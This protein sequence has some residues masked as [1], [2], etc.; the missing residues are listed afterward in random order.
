VRGDKAARSRRW[1][2]AALE[3]GVAKS[4][5]FTFSIQIPHC[6]APDDPAIFCEQFEMG[7]A[8]IQIQ[9]AQGAPI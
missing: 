1:I 4:A 5:R 2:K 7:V 8:Q 9:R 6:I 3:P